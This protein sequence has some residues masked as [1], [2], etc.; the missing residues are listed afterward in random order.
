[1]PIMRMNS[2]QYF[3]G[4]FVALASFCWVPASS[5][6]D[7]PDEQEKQSAPQAHAVEKL[8]PIH[9]AVFDTD[10]VEGVAVKAPAITD[11]LNTMLAELPQVTVLNRDQINRVATE[12]Q[13]ALSGLVDSASA[14]KLG[15]FLSAQYIVVGRASK[16]GE[17]FY[18]VL[19]IVDVETTVQTTV[20]AKATVENGFETVLQRLTGPLTESI[21][22]LQRPAAERTDADMAELRKLAQQLTGKVILVAVEEAHIGRPLRD[23]AAQMAIM[24]RLRSLGI[25]VVVPKDPPEGWKRSLL[26]T[27]KFGDYKVDYLLEGEGT[28]AFAAQIQGLT[29]CR[30]R[31]EL[32]LIPVPGRL[33]EVSDRGVAAGADLVESLA[34][35]TALEEAGMQAADAVIRRV[36]SE[37]EQK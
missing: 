17:T 20:S 12:H 30:A 29:S 31:V 25:S 1:M 6:A 36:A 5:L 13:I 11:Y 10:I 18:L 28:S 23:P 35:K 21:Q 14:V 7:A 16:I 33:I 22:R 27:G 34:A 24:Q 3:A 8:R 4:L 9:L 2:T 15:K 32:R 19:R 26:Q 37:Q